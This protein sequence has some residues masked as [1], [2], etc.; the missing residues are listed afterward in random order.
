MTEFLKNGKEQETKSQKGGWLS[1]ENYYRKSSIGVNKMMTEADLNK[2][3][4][5]QLRKNKE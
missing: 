1:K 3:S 5:A 2:L 4:K